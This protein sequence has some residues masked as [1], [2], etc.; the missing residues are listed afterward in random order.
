[1]GFQAIEQTIRER[2]EAQWPT[3]QPDVP[4]VFDNQGKGDPSSQ[5]NTAWVR[6]TVLM[7]NSSQAEMGNKQRWRRPG[8]VTVQIFIPTGDGTGLATELGDSVRDI[9]EGVTISGVI[10]RAT[11]LV[12]AGIDG[13]W[14]QY[15]SNTTFQSDELR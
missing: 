5:N 6:L 1:M 9:F 7:G 14:L 12:R 10:F 8:V 3:L 15:N 4:Y 13:S 2:F 11:S